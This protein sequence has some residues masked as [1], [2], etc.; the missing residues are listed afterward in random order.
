VQYSRPVPTRDELFD[1]GPWAGRSVGEA[2]DEA[3]ALGALPEGLSWNA[4]RYI[5]PA[6]EEIIATANNRTLF[7]AQEAGLQHIH[8]ANDIDSGKAWKKVEAQL[9]MAGWKGQGPQYRDM[10]GCD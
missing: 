5:S 4:A 10:P 6:G 1:R 8:P 9:N 3:R 7:V 2:I